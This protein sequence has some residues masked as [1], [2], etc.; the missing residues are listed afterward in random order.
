[1]EGQGS[2]TGERE[3]AYPQLSSLILKS[4]HMKEPWAGWVPAGQ[5][6]V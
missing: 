2:G 5:E 4:G 1:M 3:R 6:H